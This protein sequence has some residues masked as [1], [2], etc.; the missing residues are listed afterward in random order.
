M[1]LSIPP[2]IYVVTMSGIWLEVTRTVK[3]PRFGIY[4][5]AREYD[6][7]KSLVTAE[8]E[9]QPWRRLDSI[10]GIG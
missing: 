7:Q 6:W 10:E 2:A 4:R 3:N 8:Q 9:S 5:D 1:A